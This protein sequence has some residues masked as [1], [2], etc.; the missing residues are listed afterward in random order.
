MEKREQ[1]L[2]EMMQEL[3]ERIER[4]PAEKKAE[5]RSYLSGYLAALEQMQGKTA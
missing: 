3:A 1:T 4:A 5:L 2:H